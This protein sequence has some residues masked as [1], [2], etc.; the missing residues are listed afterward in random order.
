MIVVMCSEDSQPP[1]GHRYQGY[2]A[3]AEDFTIAERHLERYGEM[4][5]VLWRFEHIVLVEIGEDD[6]DN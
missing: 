4:P 1:A 3:G 5:K 6:E 2:D